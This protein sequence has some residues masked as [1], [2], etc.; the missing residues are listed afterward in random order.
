MA[1]AGCGRGSAQGLKALS[2]WKD[3][4]AGKGRSSAIVLP[5]SREQQ[6]AELGNRKWQPRTAFKSNYSPVTEV[7]TF[8]TD[9]D[10]VSTYNKSTFAMT[11]KRI[12]CVIAVI[13]LFCVLTVFF[14]H[15]IEGPY[16]V[17]HGPV[18][19]LLSVRAAAGLRMSIIQAGLNVT[20]L[21]VSFT[22]VLMLWWAVWI[23]EFQAE[24]SSDA[25]NPILR[26]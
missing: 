18:T 9:E 15:S 24:S 5:C 10:F 2:I 20:G 1:K 13:A 19:A 12:A 4:A 26:C 7:R 3:Y 22:L 6:S 25:C 17:V 23:S 8:P 14:F 11:L 16:S 21:W